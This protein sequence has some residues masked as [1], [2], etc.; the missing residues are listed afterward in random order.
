ML[1]MSNFNG[2]L[3]HRAL[4]ICL[5]ALHIINNRKNSLDRVRN[6]SMSGCRSLLLLVVN[7]SFVIFFQEMVASF[8]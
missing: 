4:P 6:I 1:K 7:M 3:F 2:V 8:H 5:R